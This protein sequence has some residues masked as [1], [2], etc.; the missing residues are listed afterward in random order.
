M[1]AGTGIQVLISSHDCENYLNDCFDSIETAFDGYKWMMIFCDDAST[2]NTEAA[3]NT[4]KTTTSADNVIYQKFDKASI[5]GK[6]KNRA[7]LISKTY[8]DD[9][10]VICLMDSD[11]TMGAQRISGLLPELSEDKPLV[12][13][14]YIMQVLKDGEWVTAS[15]GEDGMSKSGDGF[16]GNVTT[17]M[18]TEHLT[19]GPWCTLIHSNLIPDDG[20]FFREDIKNYDDNLTWWELKH[21]KG[22]TFTP[23]TGF[24]THYYK[25]KRPNSLLNN[26]ADEDDEIM[27]RLWT[28]KTA[29]HPIPGYPADELGNPDG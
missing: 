20:I 29:I 15:N 13:G 27:N 16:D 25:Y 18:R 12:F 8:K 5:I 14:D 2:D 26:L 6:A 7:C 10:P 11:D 1:D 28:L 22:V 24:V 23:V 19:F 4:Y 21:S 3:V 9:Y 17:E